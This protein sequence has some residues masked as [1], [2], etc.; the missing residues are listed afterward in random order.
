[1]FNRFIAAAA[2]AVVSANAQGEQERMQYERWANAMDKEGYSWEPYT[3]E[4]KDGWYLT[5]FRI[6]GRTD[7][8]AEHD[9]RHH[10]PVL[11]THGLS[12]DAVS[13]AEVVGEDG[14]ASWPLQ[15]V[16][17][18]YDV[19]M[20][21]NRGTTPYSDTHRDDGRM[22]KGEKWD[23]G[24]AEMGVYDQPA[25]FD[26][27][28]EVTGERKLTYMGYSQGTAQMFYALG[29]MDYLND[30]IESAVFIGPCLYGNFGATY[31]TLVY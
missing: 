29:S 11:I 16:D 4:T 18:G 19:W 1:M 9:G 25:F 14:S 15:L 24:F 8:R 20:A 13:W 30:K 21:S 3:V 26:K 27:V 5:L 31:D 17:R 22:S 23:F 7:G 10:A 6:T 28:L 12:M 2:L